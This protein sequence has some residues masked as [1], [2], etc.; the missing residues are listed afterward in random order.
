[1]QSNEYNTYDAYDYGGTPE[2]PE[3]EHPMMGGVAVGQAGRPMDIN[4][5]DPKIASLPRL[6]LMGPRRGGKTSIQVSS[7]SASQSLCTLHVLES[8]HE[9]L[10]FSPICLY[11]LNVLLSGLCFKKC[12]PMKLSSD[13]KQHRPWKEQ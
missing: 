8:I 2:Q 11:S 7:I 9:S 4:V 5:D 10:C 1:M 12:H 6:L 13:L 3:E